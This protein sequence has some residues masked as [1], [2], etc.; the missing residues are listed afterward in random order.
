V[1]DGKDMEQYDG[2]G[3]LIFSPDSK[4]VLYMAG[5]NNKWFV[6]IDSKE[7]KA[8]DHLFLQT[9]IIFD[10]PESLH[11]LSVT[12]DNLYLVEFVS[13]KKQSRECGELCQES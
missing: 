2:T 8:Y 12:G 7:G 6:V 1:V 10:S 5:K 13:A 9:G 4:S 11:F 3:A